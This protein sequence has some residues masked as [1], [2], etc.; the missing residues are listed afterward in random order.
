PTS[1]CCAPLSVAKVL[2]M[3]SSTHSTCSSFSMSD[4][5]R[6]GGGQGSD[7]P[8]GRARACIA[9]R[10]HWS[11]ARQERFLR[12][13][14]IRGTSPITQ[15]SGP[16]CVIFGGSHRKPLR[17]AICWTQTK[18]PPHLGPSGAVTSF[19]DHGSGLLALRAFIGPFVV[20]GVNRFDANYEHRHAA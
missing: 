2:G 9:L 16:A 11:A 12:S 4:A 13:A 5:W 19:N 3:P 8:R 15:P 7:T 14:R 17:S 10:H 18:S 20:A 1:I 6:R